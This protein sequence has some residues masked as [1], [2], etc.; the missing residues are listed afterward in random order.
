MQSSH[1][2]ALHGLLLIGGL[3]A[4]AS[5]AT[6]QPVPTGPLDPGFA[7]TWTGAF[8]AS[9]EG[10]PTTGPTETL[11][12]TVS[13]NSLTGEVKCGDGSSVPVP[14]TGGG[15]IATWSGRATCPP[16]KRGQCNA[17]VVTV[18][19]IRYTLN[20]NGTLSVRSSGT[21][22]GCGGSGYCTFSAT[23]K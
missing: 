21:W 11:S 17:A 23:M 19:N 13:G 5:C 2:K 4:A 7:K 12:I 22:G 3:V 9:C 6:T 18:T 16:F 20:S 14:A 15:N 8:T 10:A 1:W